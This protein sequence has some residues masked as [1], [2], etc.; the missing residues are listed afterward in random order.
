MNFSELQIITITFNHEQYLHQFFQS[1]IDVYQTIPCEI[2]LAD[3][4]SKD[5]SFQILKEW[6]NKFPDKIFITQNSSNLGFAQA[7][8]LLVQK[9]KSKFLLFL[10]PDISFSMDFITPSLQ[11]LTD[12]N[13][14]LSPAFKDPKHQQTY[15]NFD[16]FYD[17]WSYPFHKIFQKVFQKQTM[18]KVHWI[19]A[20]CLF[21]HRNHFELVNGFNESFFVYSEDMYL[22]KK[23][24]E[25]QVSSYIDSS[26]YVF[27]PQRE[28]SD[29]QFSYM[30][31]NLKKYHLEY[32]IYPFLI[33]FLISHFLRFK[34]SRIKILM[35]KIYK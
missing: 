6:Q 26:I 24:S 10:N 5:Q 31:E 35:Q 20:A 15:S 33:Y 7:N 4:Q 8:N 12:G 14:C 25:I 11:E 18:K 34:W 30:I 22:G 13:L 3:N 29:Q 23:L 17:H 1:F 32:P 16:V 21:M 9:S 27:H 28:I 19:Q 2:H